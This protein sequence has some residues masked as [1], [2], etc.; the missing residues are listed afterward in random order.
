[1]TARHA[2]EAI[3]EVLWPGG[4]A[5]SGWDAS[6]IERVA[7]AM[8]RYGFGPSQHTETA[9]DVPENDETTEVADDLI[10]DLYSGMASDMCNSTWEKRLAFLT[11]EYGAEDLKMMLER[12]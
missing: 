3:R 7:E 4:D 6:T 1:M 10:H 8:M 5:E 2:V 12:K 9:P 11:E